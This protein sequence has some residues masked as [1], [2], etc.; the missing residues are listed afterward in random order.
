MATKTIKLTKVDNGW[1]AEDTEFLTEISIHNYGTHYYISAKNKETGYSVRDDV[2]KQVAVKKW[3]SEYDESYKAQKAEEERQAAE[4]ERRYQEKCEKINKLHNEY[5]NGVSNL[6]FKVGDFTQARFASANKDCSIGGYAYSCQKPELDEE[7]KA[8]I[9]DSK[10]GWHWH[11]PRNWY[12]EKVEIVKVAEVT[13]EVY[14][15]LVDNLLNSEALA[16]TGV[17]NEHGGTKSSYEVDES[18]YPEN[19]FFMRATEEEREAWRAKSW[20]VGAVVTAPNRR[21][22]VVDTQGYSYARYVGL[23]I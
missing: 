3:I 13:D 19:T 10:K 23:F 4:E 20:R 17:T 1:T 22:F 9:H 15:H 6:E 21:P 16:A 12:N 18:T 2:Y 14:D 5:I 11:T 8:W 7:G